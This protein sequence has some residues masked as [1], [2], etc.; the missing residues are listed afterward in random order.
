[1]LV[2]HDRDEVF[3]LSRSLAVIDGGEI[4]T[5]GTR[6][7]VFRDP[8]TVQAARLTGCKNISPVRPESDGVYA[9]AWGLHL[10][11]A[12]DP[13]G[14]THVGIRMHAVRPGDGENAVACAVEEELETP[15]SFI[16]MLRP[17]GATETFGMELEKSAWRSPPDGRV[18]VSL[19]SAALLP[20]TEKGRTE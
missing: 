2:S 4:V 15:F 9:S 11:T 17:E 10:K 13:A 14:V 18:T 20:L 16:V 7:A 8:G 3:R 1:M 19:P 5:R 12:F 6:E